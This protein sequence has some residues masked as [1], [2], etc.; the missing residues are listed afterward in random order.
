SKRHDD[1]PSDWRRLRSGRP[2]D[3]SASSSPPA[4]DQR[5]QSSSLK[6]HGKKRS[7]SSG[8]APPASAHAVKYAVNHNRG[9][10][11]HRHKVCSSENIIAARRPAHNAPDP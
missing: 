6:F 5:R 3:V 11:S 10:N 2:Y 4:S 7:T 1:D 9:F 8:T